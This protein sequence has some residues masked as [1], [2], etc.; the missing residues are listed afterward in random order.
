MLG[1]PGASQYSITS[2]KQMSGQ[3]PLEIATYHKHAWTH[4]RLYTGGLTVVFNR[5]AE[6]LI[7]F[8]DQ[9]SPYFLSVHCYLYMT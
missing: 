1:T 2:K 9:S 5:V 7:L 6:E 8:I 4:R 3:Q